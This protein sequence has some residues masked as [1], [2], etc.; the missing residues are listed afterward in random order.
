MMYSNYHPFDIEFRSLWIYRAPRSWNRRLS[1][2][3]YWCCVCPRTTVRHQQRGVGD[4]R[5]YVTIAKSNNVYSPS[6]QP[7][8][9]GQVLGIILSLAVSG[10]VFT[11]RAIEKISAALPEL[12]ADKISELITGASGHFYKSLNAS[13][14]DVV[15]V[16]ITSAISEAFYY[17]V[18]ITAIG[19]ITSL[20][21]SVRTSLF[22]ARSLT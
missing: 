10:S 2:C 3:R 21:L 16:Q 4:D 1:K 9:V 11:N 14:R 5:W 19:F 7:G 18:C 13:D 20:F 15:V 6:D 8:N 17:L 12:P 22:F